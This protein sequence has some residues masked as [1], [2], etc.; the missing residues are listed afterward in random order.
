M[1]KLVED[2]GVLPG[3]LIRHPNTVI[4]ISV[5]AFD[6]GVRS[7]HHP[8]KRVML[9]S[10][11]GSS[12][13]SNIIAINQLAHGYAQ[14]ISRGELS[15]AVTVYAP[16]GQ[17]SAPAIETVTGRENIEAATRASIKDLEMIFHCVQNSR[18]RLGALGSRRFRPPQSIR[19][20]MISTFNR[21]FAVMGDVIH[22]NPPLRTQGNL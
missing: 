11:P 8:R 12:Q 17:L 7:F 9:V 22:C 3:R 2:C 10:E 21:W 19:F 5:D 14:S 6:G 20:Q 1:L 16:D 15:A 4:H 13:C 18:R